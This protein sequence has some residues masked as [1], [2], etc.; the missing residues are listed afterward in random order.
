MCCVGLLSVVMNGLCH[1]VNYVPCFL[2]RLPSRDPNFAH[3]WLRG[4]ASWYLIQRS[5][6]DEWLVCGLLRDQTGLRHSS[7][8]SAGRHVTAQ[9]GGR[10]GV[11]PS[12]SHPGSS[13]WLVSIL[14]GLTKLICYRFD[15]V[16]WGLTPQQQP[17]SY[18]GGEMMMKSVL[19]WRKPEYPEETT[20]VARR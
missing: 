3:D 15:L 2:S 12:A 6:T 13:L 18:Q 16:Y 8:V 11:R 7:C 10:S 9:L 20:A 14:I 17:G 4:I 1:F 19:W 5:S